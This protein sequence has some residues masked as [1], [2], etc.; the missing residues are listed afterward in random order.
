MKKLLIILMLFPFAL[1]A[2][3][4]QQDTLWKTS[5][6][7]TVN[8]SQVS[9]TNWAAGGKSSM[10]GLFMFNYAANYKKDKLSWDNTFDLRYGFIK[11]KDDDTRKSDDLI[12]ISS[13]LGYEAG[14]G[15]NYALL[16][17]FKS[18]FASGYN[19]D[20]DP[21]ELISKFMAP[22]YLNAAAGMDY[23]TDG[24]S[25]LLAPVSGKFTFVTADDINE[26]DFGLEADKKVRGELGATVKIEYKKEVLKNVTF[27]TSLNLFSNYLE[28]PQNVDVDWKTQ[29]NMKINDYLSANLITH[30]IYDDDVKIEDPDTGTSGARL[31]FMESFGVGL[32]YKF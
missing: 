32:T 28:K 15:W 5:T 27:D 31:Q 22:G 25:V 3:Q 14:S 23:K 30:L 10:S 2:Q 29:F 7:A 19:Y 1:F 18:Q 11:E 21:R 24:L 13:K 4:I 9:L 16:L 26:E 12:D 20:N 17:G 6:T 8:F